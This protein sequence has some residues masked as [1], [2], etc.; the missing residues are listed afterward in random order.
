MAFS[1]IWAL[2]EI[3]AF[4]PPWYKKNKNVYKLKRES[5][6]LIPFS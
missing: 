3:W 6:M 2:E 5:K 4:L 1:L